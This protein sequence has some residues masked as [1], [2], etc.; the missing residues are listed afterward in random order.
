MEYDL[1]DVNQQLMLLTSKLTRA[2]AVYYEETVN[3]DVAIAVGDDNAVKVLDTSLD[4]GE[5]T[6]ASLRS[7]RDA[8]VA[9]GAV[10]PAGRSMGPMRPQGRP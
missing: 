2:E 9:A 8:L 4:L 7:A 3:R 1:F 5:K 10:I 6:V